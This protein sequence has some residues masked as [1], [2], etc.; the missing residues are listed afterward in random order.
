MPGPAFQGIVVALVACALVLLLRHVARH[1]QARRLLWLVVLA[2][3]G[4][5]ALVLYTLST[6]SLPK[7]LHGRY[8]IGWYLSLL[9]VVGTAL[10]LD[11]RSGE[12]AS[13]TGPPAGAGRAAVALVVAG[14]IHTYCLCFI[15]WRYF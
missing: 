15:L 12:R 13:A 4:A 11:L 7:A 8:L 5:A 3:G 14:S 2:A 9:A 6:Q 10:A 1:G